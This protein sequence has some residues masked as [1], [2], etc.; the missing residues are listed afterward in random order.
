VVTTSAGGKAGFDL[1]VLK[2]EA[3]GRY[4]KATTHKLTLKLKALGAES[5]TVESIEDELEILPVRPRL[6]ESNEPS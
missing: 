5:P 4:S 1:W 3:D 6:G 2:A